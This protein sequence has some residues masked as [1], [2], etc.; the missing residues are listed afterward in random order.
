[1]PSWWWSA[2]VT[3]SISSSSPAQRSVAS[4]SSGMPAPRACRWPRTLSPSPSRTA[5]LGHEADVRVLLDAEE[6]G[7]A[8]A[9]VAPLVP[10]V[11]AVGLDGQL[12]GRFAG[13]VERALVAGEAALDGREPPDALDV[14][15]DARAVRVDPP[16]RLLDPRGVDGVSR[17]RAHGSVSLLSSGSGSAARRSDRAAGRPVIAR[18]GPACPGCARCARPGSGPRQRPR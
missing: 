1:M 3:A 15:L 2:T 12:N 7:R 14:E 13:Q 9:R 17:V 16:G 5:Q 18:D 8:E 11:Q 6:V 4:M 10:G